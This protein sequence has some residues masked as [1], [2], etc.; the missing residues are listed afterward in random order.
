MG[1]LTPSH[2]AVEVELKLLGTTEEKPL[3][4]E[5]VNPKS[6]FTVRG[7]IPDLQSIEMVQRVESRLVAARATFA[8]TTEAA[9]LGPHRVLAPAFT[10][11]LNFEQFKRGIKTCS[12]EAYKL[13]GV[14]PK[15]TCPADDSARRRRTVISY[16]PSTCAKW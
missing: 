14:L 4:D 9:H 3:A 8:Q 1:P 15:P 13:V 10:K 16:Q 5:H 7:R 12:L 6:D 2:S 11:H